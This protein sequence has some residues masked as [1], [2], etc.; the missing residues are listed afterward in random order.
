[1]SSMHPTV[2]NKVD[3]QKRRKKKERDDGR[4]GD[5]VPWMERPTMTQEDDIKKGSGQVGRYCS[6]TRLGNSLL[7]GQAFKAN[8]YTQIA[9]IVGQFL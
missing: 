5:A 7:F 4:E 2:K 1:M 3:R 9:Y 6:V 8:Y